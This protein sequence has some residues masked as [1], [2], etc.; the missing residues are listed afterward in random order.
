MRLVGNRPMFQ[1][2]ANRRTAMM[3][4]TY[5]LTK[6]VLTI[7]ALAFA[8]PVLLAQTVVAPTSN[9][10][11]SVNQ[12]TTIAV[13]GQGIANTCY[14]PTAAQLAANPGCTLDPVG[15]PTGGEWVNLAGTIT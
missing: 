15:N 11:Q 4:S 13:Q 1:R 3:K 14:V 12:S 6:L 2:K 5:G 10:S 8:V 7:G 9:Q